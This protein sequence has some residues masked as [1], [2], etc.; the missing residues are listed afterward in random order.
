MLTQFN[1][2]K[3]IH[4]DKGH[5]ESKTSLYVVDQLLSKLSS[6]GVFGSLEHCQKGSPIR[7]NLKMMSKCNIR[8]EKDLRE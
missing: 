5:K 7:M 8:V 2:L 1:N 3:F 4:K 6:G